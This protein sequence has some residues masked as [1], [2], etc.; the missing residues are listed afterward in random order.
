MPCHWSLLHQPSA[1]ALRTSQTRR[2][3]DHE[4]TLLWRLGNMLGALWLVPTAHHFGPQCAAYSVDTIRALTGVDLAHRPLPPPQEQSNCIQHTQTPQTPPKMACN[5]Q[6]KGV[7]PS[8]LSLAGPPP[9]PSPRRC[10]REEKKTCLLHS[11]PKKPTHTAC[12]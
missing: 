3:N 9:C 2:R 6:N 12:V 5:Q 8:N 10:L 7:G 1:P 4:D 11:F